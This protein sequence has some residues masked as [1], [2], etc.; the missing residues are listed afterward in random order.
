MK[1]GDWGVGC[2]Q[3]GH[4]NSNVPQLFLCLFWPQRGSLSHA[5]D[6]YTEVI[7]VTV[8]QALRRVTKM[9]GGFG[10]QPICRWH[11]HCKSSMPFRCQLI[12]PLLGLG[13]TQLTSLHDVRDFCTVATVGASTDIIYESVIRDQLLVCPLPIPASHSVALPLLKL[14]HVLYSVHHA[15]PNSAVQSRCA[16]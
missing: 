8:V 11:Q 2:S 4:I 16:A 13:C 1:D 9:R 5:V 3:N 12:L 7:S 10:V 14:S 15:T 6:Y